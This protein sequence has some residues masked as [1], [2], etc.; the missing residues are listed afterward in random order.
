[1][2]WMMMLKKFKN[3][4]V[5]GLHLHNIED[6]D[7]HP[8]TK[9]SHFASM[10]CQSFRD[11]CKPGKSLNLDETLWCAFGRMRLKLRIITKSARCWMKIHMIAD[12]RT[13][14]M[15]NMIM[16]VKKEKKLMKRMIWK[17][18][19]VVLNLCW[20]INGSLPAT[21]RDGP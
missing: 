4:T 19:Q 2:T 7:G 6:D 5:D 16:N 8:A 21:T 13:D 3:E 12:S 18:T 20:H 11:A 10:M 1:M 17:I 9:F 14:N 15:L